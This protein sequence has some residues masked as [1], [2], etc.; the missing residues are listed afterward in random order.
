MGGRGYLFL[1]SFKNKLFFLSLNEWGG[2]ERV[3]KKKGYFFCTELPNKN[4]IIFL[5]F[6]FYLSILFS[7][8]LCVKN[9]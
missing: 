8:L 4:L 5:I 2:K 7:S 9:C 3:K 6:L 1:F